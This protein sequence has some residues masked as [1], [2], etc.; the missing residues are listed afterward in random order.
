MS[1]RADDNLM[2]IFMLQVS[3]AASEVQS[4]AS[5]AGDKVA[6]AVDQAADQVIG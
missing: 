5:E 3:D 6:G 4:K 1:N 2:S